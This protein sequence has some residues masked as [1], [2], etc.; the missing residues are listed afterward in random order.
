MKEWL[1]EETNKWMNT[2]MNERMNE[3]TNEWLNQGINQ[4]N[5]ESNTWNKNDWDKPYMTEWINE[6]MN[7]WMNE[8][9]NERMSEWMKGMN[10]RNEW[11]NECMNE[12]MNEWMNG[13]M[14]EWNNQWMDDVTWRDV[15]WFDLTWCGMALRGMTEWMN[16]CMH[17]CMND[18]CQL[19]FS[20]VSRAASCCSYFLRSPALATVLCT[21]CRPHLLKVLPMWGFLTSFMRTG[22]LLTT[23]ATLAKKNGFRARACS[24]HSRIPELLNFPTTWW[25]WCGWHDGENACHDNHPLLGSFLT[26]LPSPVHIPWWKVGIYTY[27]GLVGKGVIVRGWDFSPNNKPSNK[28][29]P[30]ITS[31]H[32]FR[33]HMA[34]VSL[35]GFRTDPAFLW[36]TT[37]EIQICHLQSITALLGIGSNMIQRNHYPGNK[38]RKP[39]KHQKPHQFSEKT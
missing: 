22:A 10:E 38:L 21:F 13:W 8:R 11:M 4:W 31:Q 6:W 20:T 24:L 9:K 5:N 3:W 19:D 26:R 29:P 30:A 14:D 39:P 32:G 25:W 37:D 1:N 27:S 28:S 35:L 16:E 2:W 7:E 12:W 18:M 36:S 23:E 33:S 17:A 34:K 15:T